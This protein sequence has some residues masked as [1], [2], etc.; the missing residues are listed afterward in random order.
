VGKR[1]STKRSRARISTVLPS[2]HILPSKK[3]DLTAEIQKIDYLTGN[4]AGEV[5]PDALNDL[6]ATKVTAETT[7]N[8][9]DS[10]AMTDDEKVA[11]LSQAIQNVSVARSDFM[12]EMGVTSSG[13]I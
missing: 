12:K 9:I 1:K 3:G 4:F 13:R 7:L 5:T 2:D 10:Q 11:L 8:T 6:Q